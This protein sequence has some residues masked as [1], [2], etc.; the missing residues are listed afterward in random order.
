MELELGTALLLYFIFLNS[1]L[2]K[3]VASPLYLPG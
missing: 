2:D 1:N 3:L